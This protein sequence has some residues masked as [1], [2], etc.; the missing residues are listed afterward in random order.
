[1]E[2][3]EESM[4]KRAKFL[5]PLKVYQFIREEVV[6]RFGH[7]PDSPSRSRSARRAKWVSAYLLRELTY[8]TGR[9]IAQLLGYQDHSAVFWAIKYGIQKAEK[10]GWRDVLDEVEQAVLEKIF[11]A[12]SR[13]KE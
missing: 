5:M 4:L 11:A 2:S 8:M 10:E 7:Y 9:E 3:I 1:M 13:A 6:N 12:E